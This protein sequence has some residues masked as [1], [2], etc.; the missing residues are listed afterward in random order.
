MLKQTPKTVRLQRYPARRII[1][2]LPHQFCVLK[3]QFPLATGMAG[4]LLFQ[5]ALGGLLA[6]TQVAE[7][8]RLRRLLFQPLDPARAK[9]QRIQCRHDEPQHQRPARDQ[10]PPA[11]RQHFGPPRHG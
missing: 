11:R 5:C 7:I 2:R 6:G 9:A 8:A 3:F 10:G 1:C 4:P